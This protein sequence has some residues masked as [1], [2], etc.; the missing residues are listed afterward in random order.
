MSIWKKL[1]P[2][3][4]LPMAVLVGTNAAAQTSCYVS[5]ADHYHYQS[6]TSRTYNDKTG[7]TTCWST[8]NGSDGGCTV[9]F[10]QKWY[11]YI[12]DSGFCT[13]RYTGTVLRGHKHSC[14]W[15][16]GIY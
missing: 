3:A 7:F 11:A 4:A 2:V 5:T 8:V 13:W 14:K 1:V 9:Y 12:C 10:N 16:D 15:G 6:A